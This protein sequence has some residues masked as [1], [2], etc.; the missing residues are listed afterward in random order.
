MA[1]EMGIG[2]GMEMKTEMAMETARSRVGW[3]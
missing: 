2:M 3:A 1:T